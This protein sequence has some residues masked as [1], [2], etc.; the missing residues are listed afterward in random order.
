MKMR[1]FSEKDFSKHCDLPRNSMISCRYIFANLLG[2]RYIGVVI[3]PDRFTV[4]L[5]L[6][7]TKKIDTGGSHLEKEIIIEKEFM[8][9]SFTNDFVKEMPQALTVDFLFANGFRII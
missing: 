4:Q 8:A 1:M 6:T 5:H 7:A 9:I 3:I 2:I